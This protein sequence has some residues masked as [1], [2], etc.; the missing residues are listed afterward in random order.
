MRT[1]K[2]RACEP[3][4]DASRRRAR[5]LASAF[6]NVTCL[7][8]IRYPGTK[9]G[10]INYAAE[11]TGTDLLG[12]FD[13]DESV[14]PRFVGAAVERLEEA[15]VVQGRTVPRPDWIVES[16]ADYESVL[17]SYTGRRLLYLRTG[18]RLAA[19]RAVV[20]RRAALEAT[21]GYD[22]TC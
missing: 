8:N 15:D 13:A 11:V 3:D 1:G 17:L 5:T 6:E 18:F 10:A 21:G 20:V 22:P 19:R 14:D 4:D 2:G 9:A 7:V 12:V 16:L